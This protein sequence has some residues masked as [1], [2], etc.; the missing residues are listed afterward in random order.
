[1]TACY[2][3]H[4]MRSK[5]HAKRW[6]A[7]LLM[8]GC[9]VVVPSA[10]SSVLPLATVQAADGLGAGGEYHALTPAR[11]FDSRPGLAG[12]ENDVAPLGAKPISSGG[13][14][15]DIQLLGLGGIP[16]SPSDVLG[17][18]A[19]IVVVEPTAQGYLNAYGAAEPAG[20]AAI[21]NFVAG[22]TV[23]N[24]A[25]V[26]PGAGGKL[27]IK[28]AAGVGAA[29]VVVDVFGWFS[30]SAAVDRGARLVPVT[31][32]RVLDTRTGLGRASVAPMAAGEFTTL[33]IRGVD[34]TDPSKLD[35]VPDDPN[36]VGVVLNMAGV[37]NLA[38][39]SATYL[40]VIPSD[41]PAGQRPATAN[42]NLTKGQVKSNMVI[43]PID[44]VDGSIRLFNYAGTAHVVLDVVGYLINTADASTRA[45]RVVPL[46]SP[47][48]VFDTR[49]QQW[50]AVPLGPGQAEDWSFSDFAGSVTIGGVAVGKQMGV[51]GNLTSASLTRQYATQPVSSFLTVYPSDAGRPTSA[52]L[53]MAEGAPVP[54]MV[55]MKY[56]AA[57]TV[58]VYNLSGFV[59][60]V[61]D[62]SAV[63]LSD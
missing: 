52:N 37:N 40:S 23:P 62:A 18:V 46:G 13:S 10:T 20:T 54:N 48:R 39:S 5:C 50:G 56:S 41:L 44:A 8:V 7:A 47:Y 25:I 59:H 19:N 11:I 53:N 32:G 24:L 42:L 31:P 34:A 29:N 45:G 27:T 4:F 21:I 26:R 15:F 6:T 1:M 35:I 16:T 17:V 58:Q 2:N 33:K 12:S 43:V 30:T 63:I 55:I 14:T 36:V 28:L 38:T 3:G 61:Y 60:Y 51:I 9:T 57:T 22:Q 49:E